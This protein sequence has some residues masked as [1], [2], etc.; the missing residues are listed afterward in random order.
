[1][2]LSK[3]IS[4]DYMELNQDDLQDKIDK[5]GQ[6]NKENLLNQRDILGENIHVNLRVKSK[7]F[8]QF[9]NNL[10]KY[11]KLRSSSMIK[12]CVLKDPIHDI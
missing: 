1:L 8:E 6:N 4:M 3:D 5:N 12:A 9:K 10:N 2:E 11:N 7:E